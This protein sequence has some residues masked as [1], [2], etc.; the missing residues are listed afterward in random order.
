MKSRMEQY[1]GKQA[2]RFSIRK[3]HFG[4]ASVLIGTAL[5]FVGGANC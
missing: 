3:Y 5:I 1:H 2:Q 4:V